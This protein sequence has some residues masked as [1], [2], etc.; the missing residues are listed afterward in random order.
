MV[1]GGVHGK[2]LGIAHVITTE[3]GLIMMLFQNFISM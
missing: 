1:G 3:A 2:V